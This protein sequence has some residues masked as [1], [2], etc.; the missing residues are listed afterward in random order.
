MIIRHTS[1]IKN[2]A[3][4]ITTLGDVQNGEYWSFGTDKIRHVGNIYR[5]VGKALQFSD[6]YK[7]PL[8]FEHN[9]KSKILVT[10]QFGFI[11]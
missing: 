6:M 1:R 11:L 10:I 9:K 2:R 3:G 5:R 8:Y 4:Y 7:D